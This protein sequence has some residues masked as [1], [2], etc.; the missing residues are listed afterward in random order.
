MTLIGLL[1]GGSVTG[2]TPASTLLIGYLG[3]ISSVAYSLW[4]LLLKY[5]PVGKVAVFGF[6]N[7]MFGV[8]LSAILLGEKNQAFTLKGLLA[9]ILVCSGILIVN[10]SK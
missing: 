9:L 8:I 5:N 2:F 10:R 7:P 1:N 4:S 3:L 6:S